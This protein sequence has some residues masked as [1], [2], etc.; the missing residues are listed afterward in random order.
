[1]LTS[2]PNFWH[3]VNKIDWGSPDEKKNGFQILINKNVQETLDHLLVPQVWKLSSD[4]KIV[5]F[6]NFSKFL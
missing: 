5:T 1:M 6:L 4:L 2:Q 3:Y